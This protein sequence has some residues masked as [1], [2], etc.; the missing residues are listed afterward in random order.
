MKQYLIAILACCAALAPAQEAAPALKKD[1]T[2]LLAQLTA[3]QVS[4]LEQGFGDAFNKPAFLKQLK[5]ALVAA[6]TLQGKE[7]TTV[8]ETMVLAMLERFESRDIDRAALTA[9]IGELVKSRPARLSERSLLKLAQR[10]DAAMQ[11]LLQQRERAKE[12]AVLAANAKRPGVVTLSNGV[13]VETLPGNTPLR[14]IDRI[15]EESGISRPFFHRT[16]RRAV[17]DDLPVEIRSVGA[18]IPR[19]GAWVFWVPGSI[20]A[21]QQ[22]ETMDRHARETTD[23]KAAMQDLFD[24]TGGVPM[25]HGSA[26]PPKDAPQ[27]VKPGVHT[28]ALRK[29]TVWR[30]GPD[31]PI[32]PLPDVMQSSH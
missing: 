15:S 11:P 31:S 14:D 21:S 16:T 25:K 24:S 2:E 6:E 7:D 13:Q 9:R 30:D 29:I 8:S 28:P 20:A 17:Y 32:Q 5:A 4:E 18:E 26:T 10:V 12:D 19:G 22:R 1:I 23:R 3:R 27:A